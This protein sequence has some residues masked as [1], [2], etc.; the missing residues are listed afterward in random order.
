MW[1]RIVAWDLLRLFVT[2]PAALIAENLAL[3]Q[4]LGVLHRSA[5]RPR[6]QRGDRIFWVWPS[7]VWTGWRSALVIVQPDTVVRWHRQG[8]RLYWRWNSRRRGHGRPALPRGVRDLVRR[9]AQA[10]PLWGAPCIHGELLKLG[11]ELSQAAVAKYMPRRRKPPSPTWRAFLDNHI[12]QLVAVDFFTLPTATFRILF[13][14][15]V[16]AHDRRRVLH[17]KVTEH[18]T[19]IWT[20]QQIREAFPWDTAP[21]FL[22]RDH[23]GIF[24]GDFGR[25]VDSMGIEQVPTAARSPWQNPRCERLIGSIRR[26][27]KHAVRTASQ[28]NGGT[29]RRDGSETRLLSPLQR[30]SSKVGPVGAFDDPV[31]GQQ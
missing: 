15:V 3:R 22:L 17:F 2:G 1:I 10:N 27:A 8:F 24:G 9:M 18:P 31:D 21:R 6:L 11:I 26:R 19:A 29:I 28:G 4:Q 16:L 20:G 12:G 7:R 23:D 30:A 25:V 14:L 13:V 5:S